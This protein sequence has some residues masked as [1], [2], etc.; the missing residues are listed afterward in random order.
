MKQNRDSREICTYPLCISLDGQSIFAIGTNGDKIAFTIS[1][2]GMIRQPYAE[3][4][5][6]S[7]SK[8]TKNCGKSLNSLQKKTY[9]SRDTFTIICSSGKCKF[10]AEW[11]SKHTKM[12]KAIKINWTK[13]WW[14]Y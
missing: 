13:S 6:S 1:C 3:V 9:I 7:Y 5:I 14:E 11:D 8:Y 2:C 10:K 4:D 12:A